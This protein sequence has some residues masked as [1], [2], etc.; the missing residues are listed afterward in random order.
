M[1]SF[2]IT[3][4]LDSRVHSVEFCRLENVTFEPHVASF[5]FKNGKWIADH[6]SFPIS[7]DNVLDLMIIV[8]GNPG[9][10]CELTV[11]SGQGA[12]KKFAPQGPFAPN[13]HTFFKRDIQ[14]P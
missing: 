3:L 14:L 10:T 8:R 2:N 4:T 13:G 11:K 5:N 6:K 1:S 7:I 12:A 9:T